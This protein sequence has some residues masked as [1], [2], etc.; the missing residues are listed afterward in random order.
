M[1]HRPGTD[2]SKAASRPA[3]SLDIDGDSPG[4][5]V[6][7]WLV[8]I[9]PPQGA[10]IYAPLHYGH[11]PPWFGR[12]DVKAT[13]KAEWVPISGVQGKFDLNLTTI[14]PIRVEGGLSY[15]L[16]GDLEIEVPPSNVSTPITLRV[17]F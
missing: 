15:E 8:F 10:I 2:A 9:E 12:A 14:R 13:D 5:S 4:L 17:S 11:Y 1:V 3:T 6:S 7:V 16:H